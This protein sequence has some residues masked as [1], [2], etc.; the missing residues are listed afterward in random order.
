M[1]VDLVGCGAAETGVRTV[2]IVPGDVEHQLQPESGETERDKDQS[3]G[4]LGLD[5]AD[6]SFDH[7][8][9]S[10][11]ADGPESVPDPAASAPAFELLRDELRALIRNEVSGPPAHPPE[12]PLQKVSNRHGRRLAAIN[13]E[14]HHAPRVVVDGNPNPLKVFKQDWH[15]RCEATTQELS[16]SGIS[17]AARW[18]RCSPSGCPEGG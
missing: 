5:G 3:P 8:E 9:A 15:T 11:L 12:K 13:R 1:V 6:A 4:A 2:A 10:V 16:A 18:A 14:A 7:R 17:P